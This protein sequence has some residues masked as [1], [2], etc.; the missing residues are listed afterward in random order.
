L[1]EFWQ[2]ELADSCL[3]HKKFGRFLASHTFHQNLELS[4]KE[5]K[6][7]LLEQNYQANIQQIT[8]PSKM[9]FLWMS[10]F[11]SIDVVLQ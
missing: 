8:K 3:F 2:E 5:L 10:G 9:S 4:M 6:T 11:T 7:Q 1:A